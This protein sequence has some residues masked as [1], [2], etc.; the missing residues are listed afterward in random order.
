MMPT[1]P[2]R[3]GI[4]AHRAA[5]RGEWVELAR[6]VE[7]HG[8]STLGMPDHFDDQLAPVPALQCA[9]DATTTL[10]LGALV[11]D[12]DYKHP[13]VLAKEL[14]TMDVLSDGRVQIGIGAGWTTS[15]YEQS[16]IPFDPPGV[17][18]SRLVEAVSIIRSALAGEPFDFAGEHYTITRFTGTPKPVQNRMPVLI[19]GGGPRVL[20]YAAREADIVGINPTLT[21]GTID[22]S[23]FASM[24]AEAVDE[25]LAVVRDAAVAAGRLDDIEMNVRAFIVAV[26][27]DSDTAIDGIADFTGATREMIAAS[28][29]ALVGPPAKL[30]DDLL[31]RR[32][33]WGFGY[34]IVGQNDIE[35]FDPVVAALAG[36]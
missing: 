19:G 25:K 15:D 2:F 14:A 6:R 5:S 30:V 27:D 26:T 4:Q 28:P 36:T 23:T 8:Y 13:V 22:Q 32:E 3:F 7:A 34:V 12:N 24:T 31:E 16:G 29:F 18:I 35:S 11:Y 17:R 9:A 20:R 1:R 21:S 33:R 10:R